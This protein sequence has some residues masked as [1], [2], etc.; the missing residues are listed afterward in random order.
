MDESL[1]RK[2]TIFRIAAVV[3]VV[4]LTVFLL[5]ERDR[6]SELGALGY[7][8][9]FLINLLANATIIVPMPGVI[10]TTALGAVFN[11]FWVAVAAATG[12]ALGELSAYVIGYSGQRV[13]ERARWHA[14]VEHW[15][16]KYGNITIFVLSAI[17][18]PA[19][20]VAGITAG[21]MKIP[22]ARFL[23]FCLTGKFIKMLF[24]AF[25]GASLFNGVLRWFN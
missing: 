24:F 15:M 10:I 21:A 16:K 9:I 4:I 25:G 13:I 1:S 22:V 6:I 8:G 5:L 2:A 11:P 18:N 17:P 3:F 14:T 19:F 7:P 23:F 20:D 12:S